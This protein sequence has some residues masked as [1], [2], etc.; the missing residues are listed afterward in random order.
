MEE[1]YR[2]GLTRIYR[3]MREDGSRAFADVF[4]GEMGMVLRALPLER[5]EREAFL[6]AMGHRGFA[7]ERMQLRSLERALEELRRVHAGLAGDLR[8]KCRM[9]VGLGGMG[10]LLLV[11]LL[12]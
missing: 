3:R 1:P 6:E 11:I 10:G 12:M 8:E 2:S 4:A 9:A 7:D 5:G